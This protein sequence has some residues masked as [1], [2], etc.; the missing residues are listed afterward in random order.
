MIGPSV[1]HT[2]TGESIV[3]THRFDTLTKTLA[4][5]FSR[6]SALRT[7]GIALAAGLT[8]S[9]T[10]SA[11]AQDATP[12]DG[13]VSLSEVE[14]EAVAVRFFTEAVSQANLDVIDE[15]YAPDGRHNA[16]FFP[17]A[18]DPESIK[19]M[20]SALRAA[21]PDIQATVDDVLSDGDFVVVRWTITG[22]FQDEVQG[23]PPTGEAVSWTG[24]NIF[25][26]ACGRIVESWAESDTLTQL[27]LGLDTAS[28]SLATP[29]A[30]ATRPAGC[31]DGSEVTNTEAAL[32]W[33]DV[34]NTKDLSLYEAIVSP[35]TI[36]HFGLRN[37]AV[38]VQAVQDGAQS[39]L[40]AFPDL[41]HTNEEIIA[42]GDLVAIRWTAT[43][44]FTGPFL[45]AEPTGAEAAW[46]GINI[47]RFECGLL[48]ENWSE[49]SG[50]NLW[51]QVGLLDEAATPAP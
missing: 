25:Q 41:V 5:T 15:I 40:T 11:L 17:V 29:D 16:A 12:V 9:T 32:Q 48:A 39:I 3:T 24:M 27:G 43:G 22:T 8:G 47:L 31:V 14:N 37:D 50:F 42:D 6:R 46:S 28:P 38:G 2:I 13:C 51:Q 35:D 44:T 26:F 10:L 36:H 45:G 7:T 30:E 34:W 18:P 49:V 19:A 33:A 23:F 21:F 1:H 4:T 20:L